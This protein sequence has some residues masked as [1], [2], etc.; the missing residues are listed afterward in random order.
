MHQRTIEDLMTE[1]PVTVSSTDNL[2]TVLRLL[3]RYPFRHLPVVDGN[4]L[5]GI[6]SDRDVCLAGGWAGGTR[7]SPAELEQQKVRDVMHSDVVTIDPTDPPAEAARRMLANH[8]GALPT[9]RQNVCIGIVTATD[10]LLDLRDHCRQVAGKPEGADPCL[11]SH[12]AELMTPAPVSVEPSE[13]VAKAARKAHEHGVRHLPVLDKGR[14]V[15]ILSDRDIRRAM[16]SEALAE[17][18]AEL[19]HHSP[20]PP[21]RVEQDMSTGL[22]VLAPDA[23]ISAAAHALAENRVGALPIVEEGEL[24]GILSETD[25]LQRYLDLAEG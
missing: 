19:D 15:G 10:L 14:L 12:V 11:C 7:S 21:R 9:L 5:V 13:S 25:L 17:A 20:P 1:Q 4:E 3:L 2:A 24:V 22:L 16:A 18:H 8:I 6:L 23:S